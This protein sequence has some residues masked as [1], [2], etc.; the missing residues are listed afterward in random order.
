MTSYLPARS[1]FNYYP[2]YSLTELINEPFRAPDSIL[3]TPFK[4]KSRKVNVSGNASKG[5][6]LIALLFERKI[7]IEAGGNERSLLALWLI[8]HC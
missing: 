1:K 7:S 8:R 5:I 3:V 6:A 2:I 4:Y